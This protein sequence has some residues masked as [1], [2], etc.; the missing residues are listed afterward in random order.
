[1]ED[2]KK[3]NYS[4]DPVSILGTEIILETPVITGKPSTPTDQGI[5]EIQEITR[6]RYLYNEDGTPNVWVDVMM[7]FN[8]NEGLHDAEYHNDY[9]DNGNLIRHHGWKATSSFGGQTHLYNGSH[10][11]VNMLHDAAIEVYNQVEVGTKVLVK[12]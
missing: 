6:N 9:D 8:G 3:I 5:F 2:E 7:K 1:M 11:C 10:G 12:E 4:P